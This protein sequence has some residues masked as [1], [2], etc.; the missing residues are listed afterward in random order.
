M[1]ELAD[2]LDLG[3]SAFGVGVRLPSSA[4]SLFLK[5]IWYEQIYEGQDVARAGECTERSLLILGI[6]QVGKA[7][8]FDSCIRG[9]ESRI[10]SQ[11]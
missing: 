6:S 2:A 9:F 11:I 7:H 4:P 1:A 8:D 3:S 10:P 5:F